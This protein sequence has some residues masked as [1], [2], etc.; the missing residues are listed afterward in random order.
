M[1]Q[2]KFQLFFVSINRAGRDSITNAY[3]EFNY[4]RMLQDDNKRTGFVSS[5]AGVGDQ[6]RYYTTTFV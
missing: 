1:L 6:I 3:D 4:F 5:D 2:E